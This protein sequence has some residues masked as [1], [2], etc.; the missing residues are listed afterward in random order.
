MKEDHWILF[1][2]KKTTW[3]KN[4]LI[5]MQIHVCV[6]FS[7]SHT[8]TKNST[9]LNCTEVEHSDQFPLTIRQNK[10]VNFF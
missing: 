7:L 3:T 6:S 8:L 1:T 2:D 9:S 4:V 10:L 5:C